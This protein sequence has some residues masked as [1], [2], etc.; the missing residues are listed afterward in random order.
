M[1]ISAPAKP[2]IFGFL[3]I[4]FASGCPGLMVNL[5][6]Y[7]DSYFWYLKKQYKHWDFYHVQ[8][9]NH[10]LVL[11][12]MISGSLLF[13]KLQVNIKCLILFAMVIQLV[14]FWTA[15]SPENYN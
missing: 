1:T 9:F 5:D 12:G 2:T 15:L 14:G 8:V 11:F 10:I 3:L 13:T 7:L 6:K 4:I